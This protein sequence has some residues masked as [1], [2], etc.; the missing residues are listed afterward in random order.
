M[1]LPGP[2]TNLFRKIDENKLKYIENLRE[3]VAIK[4]VSA[5][6]QNRPD[7]KRM[8]EWAADKLRALGATVDI[9]DIG[10]QKLDDGSEIPLPPVLLGKTNNVIKIEKSQ[11]LLDIAIKTYLRISEFSSL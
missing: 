7:V 3:A 2:L 4:S 5:W 1:S 6:P 10:R 11:A 8:I 9:R